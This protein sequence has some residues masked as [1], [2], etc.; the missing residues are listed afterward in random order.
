[1]YI[2]NYDVIDN[3]IKLGFNNNYY[4][5]IKLIYN[6]TLIIYTFLMA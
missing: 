4:Y 2:N 6:N 1:M 5:L 3:I